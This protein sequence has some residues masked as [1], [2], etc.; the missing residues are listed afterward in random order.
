MTEATAKLVDQLLS[1]PC[2]ERIYLLDRL[3][4]SPNEASGRQYSSASRL[5]TPCQTNSSAFSVW[6]SLH[7]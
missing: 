2:E 1:L 3:I 6:P 7:E 5:R 4:E